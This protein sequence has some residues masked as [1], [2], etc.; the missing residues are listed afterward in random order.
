MADEDAT[1]V[2]PIAVDKKKKGFSLWLLQVAWVLEVAIVIL[3]TFVGTIAFPTDRLTSW[4]SAMPLITALI[5]TQGVIAGS[6]PLLAD[7]IKQS[8]GK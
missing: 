5:A 1:E 6:G 8:G 3:Y 2:L 7:L 4:L